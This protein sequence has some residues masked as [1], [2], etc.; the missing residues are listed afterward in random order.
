MARRP[1]GMTDY[2][3]ERM[4]RSRRTEAP[5]RRSA[6]I[7]DPEIAA[8]ASRLRGGGRAA[9][10][11]GGGRLAGMRGGGVPSGGGG[12]GSGPGGLFTIQD[13]AK[14]QA[15]EFGRQMSA[16]PAQGA[17]D[18]ISNDV[19][20]RLGDSGIVRGP[21]G[22]WTIQGK[23]T[24]EGIVDQVGRG[25]ITPATG[26]A[27]T[28]P[29]T[30]GG[31]I[32]PPARPSVP[33]AGG[34]V[35]SPG[36]GGGFPTTVGTKPTSGPASTVPG[37]G[38]PVPSP[39]LGGGFPSS[40]QAPAPSS[41]FPPQGQGVG[42]TTTPTGAEIDPSKYP[43][44]GVPPVT[45]TTQG[46][47]RGDR[48]ITQNNIPGSSAGPSG[49]APTS[50]SQIDMSVAQNGWDQRTWDQ[51]SYK[52]R[53]WAMRNQPGG[54]MGIPGDDSLGPGGEWIGKQ[55][56]TAGGPQ[57][58]NHSSV[59]PPNLGG[60]WGGGPDYLDAAGQAA[61]N[62]D[63][64]AAGT[65]LGTPQGGIAGGY[66]SQSGYGYQSGDQ[67]IPT[68]QRNI[69]TPGTGGQVPSPG[70]GGVPARPGP[71]T[72]GPVPSPGLGGVPA[73]IPG[74][75]GPAPAPTGRPTQATPSRPQLPPGFG[76]GGPTQIPGFPNQTG[77]SGDLGADI[78]MA[79][80][81]MIMQNPAAQ[82]NGQTMGQAGG[83]AAGLMNGG[84]LAAR[85][86]QNVQARIGG[87]GQAA[88]GLGRPGNPLGGVDLA[89]QIQQQIQGRLGGM[90]RPGQP[91][92]P[93]APQTGPGGQPIPT[94]PS[95]TGGVP[96]GGSPSPTTPG[97][98]GQ[99]GPV[100]PGG[101]LGSYGNPSIDQWDSAFIAAGAKYNVD[102][103]L[104]KAMMEI[105]SGGDGN[106][107]LDTCRA[108]GSCGPMQIKPEY[109]GQSASVPDQIDK[110]AKILADGVASG[111]YATAEDALFG[112]YFPTD[113]VMNGTSQGMYRDKVHQLQGQMGPY[114][115]QGATPP[116]NPTTGQ[117]QAPANASTPITSLGDYTGGA[118]VATTRMTTPPA[119]GADQTAPI[120]PQDGNMRIPNT[121]GV[122]NTTQA[123][124]GMGIMATPDSDESWMQVAFPNGSTI[125]TE[126]K[127]PVTW[128]V[129]ALGDCPYCYQN[130]HGADGST[131]AGYDI[132]GNYGDP[133]ATPV[134]GKVVCSGYGNGP[135]VPGF[136]CSYAIGPTF[137]DNNGPGQITLDV[138]TDAY[139]NQLLINS[140]HMG[141]STVQPGQ[142]LNPG[143]V[144]GTMGSMGGMVHTHQEGLAIC[145]GNY[146]YLDP[147][148]IYNGY[149]NNHNACEGY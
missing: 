116:I 142:V 140:I 37:A 50:S 147:T 123:T 138:G 107:S 131:H 43:T 109:W 19:F 38:G 148:L 73:R 99:P 72:G 93:T 22:S 33:G 12:R 149:Y 101:T 59:Q 136:N 75:G 85:I 141:G 62:A 49:G 13:M 117:P 10:L 23:P 104:L 91:Q 106:M 61:R 69:P 110:A 2:E 63:M 41:P 53:Q 137:E 128:E 1:R 44:T 28:V 74:S 125:S 71:G 21:D 66:G 16:S 87:A 129:P 79:V 46:G 115:P 64:Q 51:L 54:Y 98:G 103:T 6:P 45:T 11:M 42:R 35:P 30:S 48:T 133:V 36:L 113:D 132:A 32:T 57:G 120:G 90:G 77:R 130:G 118:D 82:L 15:V 65:S 135:G 124:D 58:G 97:P 114:Q 70:L 7:D 55:A 29:T 4:S 105:E 68:P 26:P 78:E 31:G 27:S 9:G 102:P 81:N 67:N 60:P 94:G 146:I 100:Q 86:Q 17:I 95:T 8:R 14:D 84:D 108:D 126:Y 127:Q 24:I 121:T 80:K 56:T 139:G 76:Q 145:N 144:Y 20:K 134:G 25:G 92:V 119:P 18:R 5:T 47:I 96:P 122:V 112:I 143:D 34:S 52:Q 89:A 39:G 83:R 40:T 3:L 111:Q 88:G